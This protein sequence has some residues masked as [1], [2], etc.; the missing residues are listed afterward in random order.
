MSLDK[1]IN[2]IHTPCK[3]CVFAKY[4][5]NTQEDCLLDYLNKYRSKNIEILEAYDDKKEFYIINEKKCIGYRENKWF[6]Q[7]DLQDSSIDEKI[8][9]YNETNILDYI[10]TI[11]LKNI[12]IDDLD[13]ILSQ[14]SVLSIQPK[15]VIFIRYSDSS[16]SFPYSVIENLLKKYDNKYKWRIQTI[17][18][19]S[20]SYNQIINNI[21]NLN[22]SYRFILCVNKHNNDLGRIVSLTNQKVHHDL[23]QFDIIS[24]KEH[25]CLIYS[26]VIFRFE[27]FHGK[28]FLNN[29]DHYLIV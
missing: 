24:N 20:L 9:K 14:I 18:D 8:K 4:N 21:V 13:S 12:I 19:Q 25:S 11:D 22:T 17:L 29:K 1:S 26:G 3:D 23:D 15:R 2:S 28:D 16:L 10:I 5:S 27:T 6:K 7:F